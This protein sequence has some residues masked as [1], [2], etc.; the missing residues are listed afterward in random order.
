MDGGRALPPSWE[1]ALEVVW[2]GILLFPAPT[3]IFFD[4]LRG[5]ADARCI[6]VPVSQNL[7]E[8]PRTA[9]EEAVCGEEMEGACPESHSARRG[10]GPTYLHFWLFAFMSFIHSICFY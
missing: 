9:Q 4:S 8:R 10:T 6:P 1:A 7:R 5:R 2:V 3:G